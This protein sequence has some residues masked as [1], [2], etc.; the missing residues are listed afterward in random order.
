MSVRCGLQLIAAYERQSVHLDNRIGGGQY[1]PADYGDH[2]CV[3]HHDP[4]G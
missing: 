4:G 3:D 2:H 1:D